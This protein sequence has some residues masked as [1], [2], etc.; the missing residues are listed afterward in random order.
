MQFSKHAMYTIPLGRY[1]RHRSQTLLAAMA[2]LLAANYP[3]QLSG[4]F[5]KR[6]PTCEL[7]SNPTAGMQGA[8]NLRNLIDSAGPL[9]YIRLMQPTFGGQSVITLYTKYKLLLLL[10]VCPACTL[11]ITAADDTT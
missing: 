3:D 10:A 2:Y 5:P 11:R 9:Q 7:G 8:V 1:Y 6:E 4:S